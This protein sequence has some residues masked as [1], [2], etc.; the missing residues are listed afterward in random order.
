LFRESRAGWFE[1]AI[2]GLTGLGGQDPVPFAWDMAPVP[3]RKTGATA[4]RSGGWCLWSETKQGDEGWVALR[5]LLTDLE[6][7]EAAY[8]NPSEPPALLKA[9]PLLPQ[10]FPGVH[11]PTTADILYDVLDEGRGLRSYGPVLGL[12][13]SEVLGPVFKGEQSAAAAASAAQAKLQA[14]Y[15]T[16]RSQTAPPG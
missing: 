13:T 8:V 4:L 7:V 2:W 6:S 11:L 16:Y 12:W 3:R 14:E 1:G 15:D 5:T 9:K 10:F